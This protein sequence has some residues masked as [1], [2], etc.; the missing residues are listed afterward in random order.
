M[1]AQA[2]K[3]DNRKESPKSTNWM[4]TLNNPIGEPEAILKAMFDLGHIR[5]IAG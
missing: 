4:G 3:V 5:Y 2:P 1:Q